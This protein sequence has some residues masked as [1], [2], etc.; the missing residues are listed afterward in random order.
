M[1]V[2][3][4]CS[5]VYNYDINQNNIRLVINH[6]STKKTKDDNRTRS[7]DECINLFLE[8]E[9]LDEQIHC[10][11]CKKQQNFYKKYDIDR[12]PPILILNL[13]RFKFAKMYR[14]K[15]DNLI[16]FPL[17]D[18]ELKDFVGSNLDTN[19]IYNLYGIIVIYI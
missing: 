16:T 19:A 3:E 12:L 9:N 1:I 17:Y 11:K 5:D 15:L 2:V 8:K 18:L 10:S 7:L 4:W 6:E 14:R 13:K